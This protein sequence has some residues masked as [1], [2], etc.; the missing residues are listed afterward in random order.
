M[1][2]IL[3]VDDSP[4]FRGL[5]KEGILRE[6]TILHDPHVE[7]LEAGDQKSALNQIV[8]EKP[9]LVL[10]DVVMQ[11]SEIEGIKILEKLSTNH[12]EIPV[13]MITSVGQTQVIKQCQE[14]GAKDYITK[15]FDS[16][17]LIMKIKMYLE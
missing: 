12:P 1:K 10:L 5:V 16:H 8:I 15:P 4:F 6:N 7:L 3:I 11:E 17:Q 14:I 2:K 9:D 13:I